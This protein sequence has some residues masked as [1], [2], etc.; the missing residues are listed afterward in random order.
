MGDFTRRMQ[1]MLVEVALES[2]Y[3]DDQMC[4]VSNC[5]QLARATHVI[6]SNDHTV[7]VCD[8]V[9]TY[10][11][12]GIL[13]QPVR[14]DQTVLDHAQYVAADQRE[15]NLLLKAKELRE[16]GYSVYKRIEGDGLRSSS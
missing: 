2:F 11:V 15:W 12:A 3:D 1:Y 8:S 16:A 6:N 13:K 5:E 4:W 14:D 10:T 7:V 9:N